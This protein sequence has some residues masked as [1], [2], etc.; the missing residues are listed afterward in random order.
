VTWL[1]ERL[2]ASGIRRTGEVSQPHLRPWATALR[3]PTDR[4]PV[5]LKA[6]GPETAGLPG[7][8]GRAGTELAPGPAD[9]R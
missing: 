8:Q 1:D 2:A 9:E 4:G 5:W 6:S 3:A 7:G